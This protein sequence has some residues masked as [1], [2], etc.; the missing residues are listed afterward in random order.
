MTMT[1]D[2]GPSPILLLINVRV[3]PLDTDFYFLTTAQNDVDVD[4]P[5][6]SNKE[7]I[8]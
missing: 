5:F 1:I 8:L 6:N 2:V 4:T 7:T 3:F